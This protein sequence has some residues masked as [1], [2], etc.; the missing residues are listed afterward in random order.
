MFAL[1]S[2]TRS[3]SVRALHTTAMRAAE[4]SALE[5]KLRDGLKTAMKAKDK[6]AVTCLKT[7]ISD[8]TNA[9][10]LGVDPNEPATQEAV[11]TAIRKA[12]E[13]RVSRRGAKG[14]G[15]VVQLRHAAPGHYTQRRA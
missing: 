6:A 4:R 13:K 2:A 15:G 9:A 11:I 8:I 12:V 5:T 10:K 1:R 14:A 7:T 3:V